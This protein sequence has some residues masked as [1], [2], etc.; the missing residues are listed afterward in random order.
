MHDGASVN[1]GDKL[2]NFYNSF[3]DLCSTKN[4]YEFFF[5]LKLQPNTQNIF[6]SYARFQ[7]ELER[8]PFSKRGNGWSLIRHIQPLTLR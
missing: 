1:T 3:Y 8:T 5:S 7:K 2:S 6:V 4:W